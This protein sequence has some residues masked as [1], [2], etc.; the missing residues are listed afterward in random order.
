VPDSVWGDHCSPI[1]D[2]TI[3]S[4]LATKRDQIDHARTRVPCV[5]AVRVVGPFAGSLLVAYLYPWW[6][7]PQ[8]GLARLVAV[9]FVL[10]RPVERGGARPAAAA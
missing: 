8:I 7:G 3:L 5:L 2:S 1:S 6:A 9:L 4:S 10:G